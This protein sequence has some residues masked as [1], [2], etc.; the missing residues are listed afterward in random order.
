MGKHKKHNRGEVEP[1]I[2]EN[3]ENMASTME[4]Q[5]L[6]RTGLLMVSLVPTLPPEPTL[7]VGPTQLSSILGRQAWARIPRPSQPTLL[8]HLRLMELQVSSLMLEVTPEVILQDKGVQAVGAKLQGIQLDGS[9]ELFR[10]T[11]RP[12][13]NFSAEKDCEAM[14]HAMK[15]AGTDERTIIGIISQRSNAQRQDIA[16]F[17]K[18]MFGRDIIA[19][20]ESELSG[21]FRETIMALFKPPAYY[22]A[23]S[24]N[25]A[26]EGNRQELTPEQLQL[27]RTQGPA[28]VV[29]VNL[30]RQDAQKLQQAGVKR[31]GTDES[32]FIT[33][34]ALRH[35][36]QL[37]ATFDEYQKLTGKDLLSAIASETSGDFETGL[38]AIVRTMK[39]RPEYF[40]DKLHDSIKFLGTNDSRLIR[41]VV[42]RSEIDLQDIKDVYLPKYKKTL[43]S[44]VA[45]DTSGDYKR[46]LVAIIGH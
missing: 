46:L 19:D 37:Q 10:P 1:T 41:I 35:M 28:A 18:T 7:P 16:K 26:M 36:Y 6:L 32:A 11:V 23:W 5:E 40:A 30:A 25:N 45:S 27:I 39:N 29:D 34:L 44:D 33:V 21:N 31:L 22:D 14:R 17:Y 13:P 43:E 42:S 24:L 38:R 8:P 2:W 9:A 12:A 4:S 3:M 20:L 15:G